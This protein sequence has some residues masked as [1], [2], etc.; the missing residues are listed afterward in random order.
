MKKTGTGEIEREQ[1]GGRNRQITNPRKREKREKKEINKNKKKS[2][3]GI[4]NKT[5]MMMDT[6]TSNTSDH[7]SPHLFCQTRH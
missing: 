7:R 3:G 5:D 4:A 6:I 2:D 1:A